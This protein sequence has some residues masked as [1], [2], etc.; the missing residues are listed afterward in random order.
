[1]VSLTINTLKAYFPG[2]Y[3]IRTINTREFFIAHDLL[4]EVMLVEVISCKLHLHAIYQHSF[5]LVLLY[6]RIDITQL[7]LLSPFF[8]ACLLKQSS[9]SAHSHCLFLHCVLLGRVPHEVH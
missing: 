9:M 7:S 5:L 6:Y 4:Q 8:P 1:M 2:S 3:Q